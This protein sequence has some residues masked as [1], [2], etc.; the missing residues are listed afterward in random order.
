[1]CGTKLEEFKSG[2]SWHAGQEA[3]HT[4]SNLEKAISADTPRCAGEYANR[5]ESH[6]SEG[7][8]REGSGASETLSHK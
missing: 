2:E 7:T 8:R 3:W 4:G 1:M 6:S 5:N